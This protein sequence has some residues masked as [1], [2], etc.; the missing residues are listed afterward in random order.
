MA[1]AH[2]FS[3]AVTPLEVL[4]LEGNGF[5]HGTAFIYRVGGYPY[6][7][8]A[9][10]VAS[11]RNFFTRKL[12][13]EA[14]IPNAFRVYAP[15]FQQDGETVTLSSNAFTLDLTEDGVARL[16]SPPTVFGTPVDVAVGR[17]PISS[18][19]SG[20][21]T[22]GG[23]NEF[24]WGIEERLASPIAS[25]IGAD[26]FVLG[27]PLSTYE[28]LRTPIWKR[29]SLAS[30]PTFAIDPKCTFLIDVN[31]TG[32]MSGGPIVRRVAIATA[33]DQA[34]DTIA[35]T[36]DE[37]VIGVYSGRTLSGSD[38][39][40]SLGYGWPIDVVHAII[41]SGQCFSGPTDAETP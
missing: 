29:G 38:K 30:E 32:G 25:M 10:H 40:F 4:D 15:G 34:S 39:G 5:T 41:E 1:P 11:G 21:F 6:L 24:E 14:H 16:E 13:P 3:L 27:Y 36:Y 37:A 19:K 18:Q 7:V 8:T 2:S 20:T 31:S 33:L 17:L 9:W 23:L 26:V 22:S 35:E 28:G 12:N